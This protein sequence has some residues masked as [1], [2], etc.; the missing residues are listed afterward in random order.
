MHSTLSP[1][2]PS[3]PPINE[4]AF[5]ASYTPLYV[6]ALQSS[7]VKHVLC[8]TLMQVSGGVVRHVR[9]RPCVLCGAARQRDEHVLDGGRRVWR[10]CT[11]LC[12]GDVLLQHEGKAGLKP[13]L[14]ASA[15]VLS[16]QIALVRS[17]HEAG[18]FTLDPAGLHPFGTS[19]A[20]KL[21][22]YLQ[23]EFVS[24]RSTLRL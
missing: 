15:V 17:G 7:V 2:P 16:A 19:R 8:V 14:V 21:C 24:V 5:W 6:S 3:Y 22:I 13:E 23:E 10:I 9:A 1:G 20:R 12:T 11:G 18:C 4:I